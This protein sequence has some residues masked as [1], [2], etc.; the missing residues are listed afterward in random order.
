MSRQNYDEEKILEKKKK[1]MD[2]AKNIFF[3]K[4]YENTTMNEI[5]RTANMAKG[6]LYLYFSSKK[7]L[8]FSLV[9]EGLEILENLIKSKIKSSKTGLEKVLDMGRVYIQFYREYPEYYSFIIKYESEKA[10]L[11]ANEP[12][13]I[14]SYEKSEEIYDILRLL[15]LK[16]INDGSI[17]ED[18]DVNKIAMILWLQTI[19]VVQQFELRKKLYENWD[20]DFPASAILDFYIDFMEKSLKK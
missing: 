7:D 20:E 19:G 12:L 2:I 1:I 15:I 10:D 18:I 14:N 5:A 3:E 11:D 6:T 8:F 17:R 16:G 13:V 9:Y 4:G